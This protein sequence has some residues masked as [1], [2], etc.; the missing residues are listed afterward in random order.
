VGG[1]GSGRRKGGGKKGLA[2]SKALSRLN[3]T[4]SFISDSKKWPKTGSENPNYMKK[5]LRR[6]A[7]RLRYA[8][9]K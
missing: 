5:A 9:K 1:P 2:V 7:Q 8:K 4:K 6:D 3:S